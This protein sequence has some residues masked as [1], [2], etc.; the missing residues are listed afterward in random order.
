M[1]EYEEEYK[2][3]GWVARFT[4]RESQD[5]WDDSFELTYSDGP[6]IHTVPFHGNNELP[7]KDEAIRVAMTHARQWIDAEGARFLAEKRKEGR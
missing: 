3:K 7:S 1:S 6:T 5:G 2:H 4:G